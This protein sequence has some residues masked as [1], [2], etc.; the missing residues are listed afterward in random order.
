VVLE[1]DVALAWQLFVG[2]IEFVARAVRVPPGLGPLIE[3]ESDV[4]VPVETA[5]D[6]AEYMARTLRPKI[7]RRLS[8]NM[9][10]VPEMELSNPWNFPLEKF[11]S[12][13]VSTR[14][15]H[16]SWPVTRPLRVPSA[17]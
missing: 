5:S 16:F 7:Q 11:Q 4:I 9:R 6:H 1:S 17:C 2:D 13:Y 15:R 8:E 12:R 14:M 10:E 3:V